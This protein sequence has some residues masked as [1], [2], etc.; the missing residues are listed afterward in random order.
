MNDSVTVIDIVAQV[1]DA[2]EPGSSSSQKNVSKLERS[3][4]NLQKQIQ[5]MKGKSKLEVMATLKDT[6][7]K[8]I[9]RVA[10]AGK[11]IAGKVWTVT[12]KAVDLV[13]APFKKVLGLIANPVTQAAAFAGLSFGA[14]DT[15]NTFKD[16]EQGMA[17]VKAISGATGEEFTALEA[18]A[19]ELGE[20]TMFSAA[21]AAE[22]MENLA[23]AGWKSKDIVAG[24]PGLLN[25]AAAGSVDLAT[26][27]DV[28]ASALAQFKLE[29][30]EAERVADVLAATAT[31]SKTD[32]AGLGESLKYAGSLAGALGYSIEDVS[33][34]FGIMGNAAIDG[35]SAG[36]ALRATLARMSK[37][38]GLTAEE[39]NAVVDA[40]RKLGVSMTDEGGKAKSLM[41][42]MKDMRTGYTK[43]SASEQTA[44]MTNLAGQNALS[45]MLAIVQASDEEFDTLTNAIN[46][47]AGAAAEMAGIKM[48]TL[49]GSLYYLQSAAEGVKI[50]LGE[51]L[52]PYAKGLADWV[53]AHMPDIQKAAGEA[54]DLITG[55]I[56]DVAASVQ[57]LTASPEWQNAETLWEKIKLAWD[58]IIVEPFT[59][60]W[61]GTG[62]AWLAGMAES[63]GSGLGTALHAGIMGLLG[64]DIG[65]VAED[66][67]SIGKSFASAFAEGFNGKEV[68][69]AIVT[70]IKEGL[71]GLVLDAGRLLPGGK[72][73]SDTSGLS[74]AVLG[75]GAFKTAKTLYKG[76]KGAKAL[77]NGGK[78]VAG[79]IKNLQIGT[80][81][82]R[83]A[84]AGDMESEIA[85]GLVKK[86]EMGAGTQLGA[87]FAGTA[88]K[89]AKAAPILAGVAATVQTGVDAYHGVGKAKEW[90]GSD[91][92]GAKAASG[93]GAAL[94]GT[95]SGIPGDESAGKKALNVGG[96]A[97]KGAGIGAAIGSII[98]GAGTAIGAGIGAGAG[99]LGA[100]IG[101]ENIAKGLFTAGTAIKRFFTE[102][103]P[104]KFRQ[105]VEG[106][107]GFFTES[108]PNALS[109][110]KEKIGGFFMETV[111]QKFGEFKDGVA[112]FFTEKVGGAIGKAKDKVSGFFTET[113]PTKFGEFKDGVTAFFTE[114]VGG[115]VNNA[116]DKVSS[117][118]TETVPQKFEE[119]KAGL[120]KLFVEKIP[121]ALGYA[122]G[123]VTVFFTETVPGKFEEL[124][125]GITNF[126]AE[127]VPNAIEAAGSAVVNFFTV[128]VPEFFTNLWT[129]ITSFFAETVPAAIE[130]VGAALTTFFTETVPTFFRNL[131]DGI[132]GFFTET[133]PEAIATVSEPLITFFTETVPAFFGNLW[134][135]IAG[136]FTE[137]VPEA[138]SAV[139][140]PLI[141]FFT[142]TVPQFFS[143]MWEDIT[144]FFTETVPE[145]LE[146]IGDALKTFFTETVPNKVKEIWDGV[147]G[148]FTE[149]IPDA[150]SSIAEGISGFFQ[151]IKNKV[152][153][154]FSNLKNKVVGFL[155]GA[156]E[157]ASAG[158][159]AATEKHAEGGIMTR[160]H[161]G[162]VAEDGA[163]AII[164]L[165]SKRRERGIS[166]WEKAG[167]ILGMKP[168]A[169]GGIAGVAEP[170][171]ENAGNR[172]I[173][174]IAEPEDNNPKQPNPPPQ[175][176][177]PDPTG[178]NDWPDLPNWPDGGNGSGGAPESV[179]AGYAAM[180]VPVTIQNLILEIHV[181][182][183]SAQDP[184]TLAEAIKENIRGMTDEIAYRLAIAIQQAFAN[185]PVTA[186]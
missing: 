86:G 128:T 33:V 68:G 73:A 52:Q 99:A 29:A 22:A 131:W 92:M 8:G 179:N 158:Y 90:T 2:T 136:F 88:S 150:V 178:W 176:N 78:M 9:Q 135:G 110:A 105:F 49:Q 185:K 102:T 104:E 26:A 62:K 115:A 143:G 3:M 101:G 144:G 40:M 59:E 50:A 139:S 156:S 23:M 148:F 170:E 119:F 108:V 155:S 109:R 74:A 76:Y 98:P 112:G 6:A 145:A 172:G 87:Q 169:E 175:P 21:Q 168:Y 64:I 180:T 43:L 107:K 97:L 151:D 39:S 55:K 25:L 140:E 141:A 130:T 27:A 12:L 1:T 24:M 45:G 38:E 35:S 7:S 37:Q 159:T 79:G 147:L 186:W 160:P 30:G 157:S 51:K 127:T 42:I 124:W 19:K 126:F 32:V 173:T 184:Q 134:D 121:Y 142:E 125:T 63:V 77:V 10:A 15:I 146:T 161:V 4:M 106:T 154:F 61:N 138:V 44:T 11:K 41:A 123:K 5:S 103:V 95:G 18:A 48:D 14:A 117:F 66:G 82:A 46:N 72:E 94:G 85:L 65:G 164:P 116:K 67:V 53:T 166:L 57:E 56:D 111:P 20:T 60:W 84:Q 31:N 13:T 36:T 163:E 171:K 129:D 69:E 81:I 114:K 16:F 93:V 174:D 181:D 167:Q 100:A 91:S 83:A 122:A 80:D 58:K 182:G 113:I 153:G 54:V 71:K 133:V 177:E 118:F 70:A 28:T 17:N 183:G 120:V 47:S 165:S 152:T 162:L 96:G 75:Y 137:T 89:L 149:T 34:A 132:V